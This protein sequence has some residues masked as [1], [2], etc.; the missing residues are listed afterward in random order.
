MPKPN[1]RMRHSRMYYL[2]ETQQGEVLEVYHELSVPLGSAWVL[3][4]IY[5]PEEKPLRDKPEI[6][7]W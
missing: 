2:L 1:W 3:Y 6:R 4:R 5:G 7:L